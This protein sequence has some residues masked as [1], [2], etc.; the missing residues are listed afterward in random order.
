MPVEFESLEFSHVLGRG[1]LRD[2]LE[3]GMEE[4]VVVVSAVEHL[5]THVA[6]A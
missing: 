2:G 4:R 3:E 5:E 1:V 6:D